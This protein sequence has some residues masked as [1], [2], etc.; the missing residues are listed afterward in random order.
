M[1]DPTPGTHQLHPPA[2]NRVSIRQRLPLGIRREG[3]QFTPVTLV[4]FNGDGLGDDV[5]LDFGAGRSDEPAWVRVHSSCLTGD[6]FGSCRCDCGQ[7]LDAAVTFLT[8]HG[9]VLLYLQQEGRG[10][11]L[12]A[13]IDAYALQDAGL[14]T[15][16]ANRRLGYPADGRRYALAAAMLGALGTRSVRLLGANPDK[17]RQ[18]EQAGIRVAGTRALPVERTRENA[19]YLDAKARW[20]SNLAAQPPAVAPSS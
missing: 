6:I 8:R 13:K 18:L 20:F 1:P 19:A 9:G 12:R 14:D 11:G 5:A 7:Q 3:R 15:F 17:L 2:I 10:I 4:T 16:E